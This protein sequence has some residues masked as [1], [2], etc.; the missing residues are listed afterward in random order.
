MSD[1]NLPNEKM[2][3]SAKLAIA[4]VGA[5]LVGFAMVGLNKQQS[6]EDK[7][8]AAMVRSYYNL[9]TMATDI[10][11]KAIMQETGTQI[12]NHTSIDTDKDTYMTLKWASEDPKKDGFKNASCKI[13]SVKGGITELI[14]DD[15]TIV[16]R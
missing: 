11:P 2:S 8:N 16:K 4:V 14:I 12:Y 6:T 15:K 1:E 13:E 3:E 7:E 5:I 10:C 9:I